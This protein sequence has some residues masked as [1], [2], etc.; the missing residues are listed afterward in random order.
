[1]RLMAVTGFLKRMRY[2]DIIQSD[3]FSKFPLPRVPRKLPPVIP[4]EQE[5][6]LIFHQ[7]LAKGLGLVTTIHRRSS[8]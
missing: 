7:M 8:S 1:M 4:A 3:F 2:Y 6:E 5:I